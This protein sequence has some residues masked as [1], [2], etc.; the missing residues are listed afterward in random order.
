MNQKKITTLYFLLFVLT[1]GLTLPNKIQGQSG[2]PKTD[3]VKVLDVGAETFIVDETILNTIEK[4]SPSA[5]FNLL[6]NTIKDSTFTANRL[7]TTFDRLG[8]ASDSIKK[9]FLEIEEELETRRRLLV[10]TQIT[11]AIVAIEETIKIKRIEKKSAKSNEEIAAIENEIETLTARLKNLGK[12]YGIAITGIDTSGFFQKNLDVRPLEDELKDIIAPIVRSFKG[13]MG[14]TQRIAKINDEITYYESHI[15]QIKDGIAKTKQVYNTLSDSIAKERSHDILEFWE[16]Q[17]KEFATRLNVTRHHLLDEEM[18]GEKG[19]SGFSSFIRGTGKNIL[20]V[21]LI[22]FVISLL[23]RSLQR[24]IN[25]ISPLHK[26]KKHI[27]GANLIDLGLRL[28]TSIIIL[29]AAMYV[30][31]LLNDWVLLG[32]LFI[33][34]LGIIWSAKDNVVTYGKELQLLLNAGSIRQNERVIYKGISYDVE[35][36]GLFS[37]INN[38]LLTGGRIR[39]P[40][41]E[42][43]GMNSRPYDESES[44]FPTSKGDWIKIGG[45]LRQIQDQT[46]EYVTIVS[47]A[48]SP[49]TFSTTSFLAQ[50]FIN[51]S[52]ARFDAA[53][54]LNIESK[55][56]NSVRDGGTEL[57]KSKIEEL[58]DANGYENGDQISTPYVAIWNITSSSFGVLVHLTVPP[59]L[60]SSFKGINALIKR[61][62]AEVAQEQDWW[63]PFSIKDIIKDK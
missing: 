12:D 6:D 44:L 47:K 61:A 32:F 50:N 55:H 20:L 59:E 8:L 63:S 49:R 9:I 43:L 7:N 39:L 29:G 60:A 34:V 30:L 2:L 53:F 40:M 13:L 1:S 36:I 33:F 48:G 21:L 16:Q 37:Y 23:S 35:K 10:I 25:K 51:L 19:P 31:L 58:I 57:I 26:S 54:V 14:G 41:K 42:L 45:S 18:K 27:F 28:L 38:P 4:Y 17:E 11:E 62:T 46:P 56:Y 5:I 52:K 15:L 3:T 22:V 24:L